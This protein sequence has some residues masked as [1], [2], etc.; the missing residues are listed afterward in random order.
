MN[1]ISIVGA[2]FLLLEVIGEQVFLFL[3]HYNLGIGAQ[4][5]TKTFLELLSFMNQIIKFNLL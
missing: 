2:F 3:L 5:Q 1:I 4:E